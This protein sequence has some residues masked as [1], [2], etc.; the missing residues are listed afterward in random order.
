MSKNKEKPQA[1]NNI[2]ELNPKIDYDKPAEAIE[3]AQTHFNSNIAFIATIVS[4]AALF[5]GVG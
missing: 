4:F 2:Q 1:I 5:K 3:K